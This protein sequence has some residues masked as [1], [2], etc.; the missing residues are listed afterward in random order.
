MSIDFYPAKI[1]QHPEFGQMVECAM[2]GGIWLEGNTVNLANGN[3]YA[4]AEH[5]GFKIEDGCMKTMDIA[6]FADLCRAWFKTGGHRD[7]DIDTFCYVDRR[8]RQ[9]LELAERGIAAG[10]THFS[11]A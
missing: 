10:A 6:E 4:V 7:L 9:L 5:L 3:A 2:P 1:V 8:A 11:G